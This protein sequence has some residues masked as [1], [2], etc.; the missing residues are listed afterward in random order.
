MPRVETSTK[1]SRFVVLAAVC[2]VVA[3]LYFARDVLVPLALAMLLSFL[4]G[5]L[6][7]RLER[8]GVPR[9]GAVTIVAVVIF[10]LLGALAWLVFDKGG[11]PTGLERLPTALQLLGVGATATIG[12]VFL[13]RAFATGS[14]TKVASNSGF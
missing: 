6:V 8:R 4:L 14:P 2:I 12:Q 11:G 5:P 1:G 10:T 7:T 9:A 13:T 3:A